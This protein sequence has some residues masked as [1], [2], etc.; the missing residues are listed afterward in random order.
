[1]KPNPLRYLRWLT[2]H[3][4]HFCN[5]GRWNVVSHAEGYATVEMENEYIWLEHA[6]RGGAEGLL[7]ACGVLGTVE[8]ER[9]GPYNGRLHMRW[10]AAES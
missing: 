2:D 4:E 10:R 3:R 6:H 1:L 8:P 7:I 9:E 5:Y